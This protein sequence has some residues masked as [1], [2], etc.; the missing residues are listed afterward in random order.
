[1]LPHL[2]GIQKYLLQSSALLFALGLCLFAFTESVLFVAPAFAALYL[3]LL[4]FDFKAAYWILIIL[5]PL[6]VHL[7]FADN[8]FSLSAPSEPV[9]W[10]FYILAGLMLLTDS[11]L[12]P[13]WL[14][15]NSISIIILMQF[16]WL[17]VAV[18]YSEVFSLSLKYLIAKSWYLVC[19][20]LI[21]IWLIREKKDFKK[22]FLCFLIP[23]VVYILIILIRHSFYGF[24]FYHIDAAVGN[25][26][27][28]HVDYASVLSMFFPFV[29]AA[30]FVHRKSNKKYRN[31]FLL[32]SL[33]F[34]VAIGFSYT[35]AAMGGIVFGIGV[36]IAIRRR[37]VN[38]VIPG[39]YAVVLALFLFFVTDNKFLKYHPHFSETY[40]HHE[41]G[42]HLK[43]TLAGKDMSSVER[44]YRWIAA[45]RMGA[46]RPLTGFGPHSFY[47]YYKPYTLS[48]YRTYVSENYERSTTHNYFLYM[49]VEQ[50]APAMLLYALL[51]I[52]VLAKTQK[53]YHRL[54]DPFYRWICLAIGM[55]FSICFVNNLFSELI[56]TDKVGPIF[57]L[58][59]ASLVIIDR[60]SKTIQQSIS[61]D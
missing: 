38:W 32:L 42:D 52:V 6:S 58:S 53:V 56:E 59:L 19:F 11:K 29:L 57:Y 21:P 31:Y 3:L 33:L 23:L 45:V 55:S 16:L 37:L 10:L 24:K 2:M 9:M 27:Y 25:L 30:C 41:F 39:F 40:M 26:F 5:V 13:K 28:K 20:F 15:Q 17:I 44:V 48:A 12:L 47:F 46:D 18:F 8:S 34:L 54:Q 60:K 4:L 49:L 51:V 7:E 43:A 36:V 50:G 35:R 14:L 1:M 61:L 22:L